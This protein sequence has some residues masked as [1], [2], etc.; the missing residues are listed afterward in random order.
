M[1]REVYFLF[2][3]P[4][5]KLVSPPLRSPQSTPT[6]PP[7]LAYLLPASCSSRNRLHRF[8]HVLPLSTSRGSAVARV[9]S[10]HRIHRPNSPN[11]QANSSMRTSVRRGAVRASWWSSIYSSVR[12][13]LSS[14]ACLN[15]LL[16]NGGEQ[17][18][19]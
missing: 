12:S 5:F 10:I 18:E 7:P 14:D 1:H 4:L 17:R 19:D 2:D 11:L 9:Q 15:S 16:K 6:T 13:S 3:A 8:S